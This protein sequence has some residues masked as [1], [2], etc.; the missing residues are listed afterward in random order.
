MCDNRMY[1]VWDSET[2]FGIGV[3]DQGSG[4]EF[5]ARDVTVGGG[6]GKRHRSRAHNLQG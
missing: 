1:G 5:G 4:P 2:E 6:V 3:R